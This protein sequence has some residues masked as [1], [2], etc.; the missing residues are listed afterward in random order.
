MLTVPEII[1]VVESAKCTVVR[2]ILRN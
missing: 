2:K 1:A